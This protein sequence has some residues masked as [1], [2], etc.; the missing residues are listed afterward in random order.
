MKWLIMA[1]YH[2]PA[3]LVQHSFN[4]ASDHLK[5]TGPREKVV[6]KQALGNLTWWHG[7]WTYCASQS[8]S[9]MQ[10]YHQMTL[11]EGCSFLELTRSQTRYNLFQNRRNQNCITRLLKR[12]THWALKGRE[13]VHLLLHQKWA[14]F[15]QLQSTWPPGLPWLNLSLHRYMWTPKMYIT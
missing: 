13:L 8:Q 15:P 7:N 5:D 6:P 2:V 11:Y 9:Q 14:N 3:L 10:I 4:I 12:F 1:Q